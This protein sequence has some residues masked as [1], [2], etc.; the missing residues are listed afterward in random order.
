MAEDSVAENRG[1]EDV[2]ISISVSDEDV[3]VSV[4]E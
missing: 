2:L 3:V 4:S 1:E